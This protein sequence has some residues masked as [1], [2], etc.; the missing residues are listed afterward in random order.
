MANGPLTETDLADINANLERLQLAESEIKRAEAAGIDVSQF[1][2]QTN[3]S[4]AQLLK[5]KQSYFPG[6]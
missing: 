2:K 1:R 5:I 3:E 4:R 6:Q